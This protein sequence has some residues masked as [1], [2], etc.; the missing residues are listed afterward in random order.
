LGLAALP[1]VPLGVRLRRAAWTAASFALLAIVLYAKGL[2]CM[3][4]RLFHTPCPGCGST[5]AV[6]ALTRGD[7]PG[8]LHNNP[9]GPVAAL[10]IGMLGLQSCVSV[11][12]YGD[13]RLTGEGHVGLWVKRALLVVVALE[14][15][16]WIARF[17]G[18]FGG[19]VEV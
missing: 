6:I 18:A 12:R 4:A 19:P 3:F 17:F 15:M 8:V 11:L 13:F 10:L 14:V 1:A 2:P 7:W 16:L 5:R 9:L